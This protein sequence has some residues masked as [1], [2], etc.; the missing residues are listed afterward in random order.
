MARIFENP[1][2]QGEGRLHP[3]TLLLLP[4]F[5]VEWSQVTKAWPLTQLLPCR[6]C[7][8]WG[9]GTR[10]SGVH[11]DTLSQLGVCLTGVHGPFRVPTIASG[12]HLLA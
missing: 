10:R 12:L 6:A 5:R 8:C 3:N 11:A 4:E 2:V 7:H 9:L 1:G